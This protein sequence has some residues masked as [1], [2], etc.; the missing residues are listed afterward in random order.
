MRIL[1]PQTPTP[2]QRTRKNCRRTTRDSTGGTAEALEPPVKPRFHP[3]R[4]HVSAGT[5]PRDQS[6]FWS[7]HSCLEPARHPSGL[8]TELWPLHPPTIHHPPLQG[9]SAPPSYPLQPSA[10]ESLEAGEHQHPCC[11]AELPPSTSPGCAE[12]QEPGSS[13]GTSTGDKHAAPHELPDRRARLGKSPSELC[14]HKDN[15]V[16]LVSQATPFHCQDTQHISGLGC[17][18]F[19]PSGYAQPSN[20]PINPSSRCYSRGSGACLELLRIGAFLLR[21]NLPTLPFRREQ[22]GKRSFS[23]FIRRAAKR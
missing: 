23:E 10:G 2:V 1:D 11:G 5:R 19:I 14:L 16:R 20:L 22:N 17:S 7:P 6:A 3:Q 9:G 13:R 21:D 8:G 4:L 18:F 15:R 12:E